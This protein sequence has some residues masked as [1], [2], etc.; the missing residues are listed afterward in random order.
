VLEGGDGRLIIIAG[1]SHVPPILA[2]C[3]RLGEAEKGRIVLIPEPAAKNTG[4]AIACGIRWLEGAAGGDRTLLVLTCD[5][6]IEP[7]AAFK[8]DAAAAAFFARQNRL[9]V[10]GIPPSAPETGYGYIE[11]AEALSLPSALP[12]GPGGGGAEPRVFRVAAF[13]EK[14]GRAQAEKFLGA[15]NFYW[16]SG[17]FG[18]SLSFMAGE[19]QARA[20]EVFAPFA[21]L[22]APGEGAYRVHDGVRV[23]EVWPGLAEA[24]AAAPSRSFDYAVV[25]KCEQTVMVAAD[26]SWLDVGSWDEYAKLRGAS[27]AEVYGSGAEGCFVDADI[28]VA[29]CGVRD[30]IV[31]VRS[32]KD[33]GP[34]AV[35]I[36]QKGESQRV[37]DITEQI[38]AAG[39]TE[40]L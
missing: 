29:L 9:A 18:F 8:R 10:F 27:P 38:R 28:P 16:N 21:G 23:L 40:L 14:P 5:H 39:R 3:A 22:A 20:P 1:E 32:G 2:A 30:L 6:I 34:P 26:F 36:T 13:R 7:L 31:V 15:G 11:A 35:L 17:M 33:G 4:P 25:E 19:L 37:K 24:Y 12:P